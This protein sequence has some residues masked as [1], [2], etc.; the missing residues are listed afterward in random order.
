MKIEHEIQALVAKHG[1]PQVIAALAR[2]AH[3]SGRVALF[4]RLN[5]IYEWLEGKPDTIDTAKLS[6]DDLAKSIQDALDT[7]ETGAALVE[8]ARNA[9]K[10]EQAWANEQ[11]RIERRDADLADQD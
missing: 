5:K 6:D 9:H 8:V 11:R 1:Y 3:G 7:E 4:N 10:A 2:N